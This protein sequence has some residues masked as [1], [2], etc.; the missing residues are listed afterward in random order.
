MGNPIKSSTKLFRVLSLDGRGM[1]GIYTAKYL[2]CLVSGSSK[3]IGRPGLDIGKGFDLIVGTSTGG[4]VGRALLAGVP[5][6]TVVSLCKNTGKLFFPERVP[7]GIPSA[8][9][10]VVSLLILC[11][12]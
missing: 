11:L 8:L 5:L 9:P 4:I 7:T 3:R 10:D 1:R 2:S 12:D 6:K